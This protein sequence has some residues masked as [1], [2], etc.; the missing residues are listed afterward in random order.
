MAIIGQRPRNE[1]LTCRGSS[2][3]ESEHTREGAPA[4]AH[5]GAVSDIWEARSGGHVAKTRTE[6]LR[7]L[8]DGPQKDPAKQ[9]GQL[10]AQDRAARLIEKTEAIRTLRAS[11]TGREWRAFQREYI[12]EAVGE[13]A[14]DA[15]R[16]AD[17]VRGIFVQPLTDEEMRASKFAPSRRCDE[18]EI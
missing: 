11:I 8:V 16:L 7:Q 15:N 12:T 9:K 10:S 17:S 13:I 4:G 14:A 3:G 5:A 1:R 2:S 18:R 6:L